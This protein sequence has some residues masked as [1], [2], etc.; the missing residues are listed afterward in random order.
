MSHAIDG[1]L[2]KSDI[3]MLIVRFFAV[4][5][6]FM[7]SLGAVS[8]EY[9]WSDSDAF[10]YST[11]LAACRHIVEKRTTYEGSQY[12]LVPGSITTTPIYYPVTYPSY[13]DATVGCRFSFRL[14]SEVNSGNDLVHTTENFSALRHGDGCATG[15]TYDFISG[16]CG[17]S[18]DKGEPQ[19]LTCVGNPISIVSGNKFQYD[20]DYRNGS[21][22]FG[23]S[24]NSLDGLWRATFSDRLSFIDGGAKV[25]LVKSDGTTTFYEVKGD[26]VVQESSDLGLLKKEGGAWTYSSSSGRA[27]SFDAKGRLTQLSTPN[28]YIYNIV[29]DEDSVRVQ[30][31]GHELALT[32]DLRGQPVRL[33]VDEL[34]IEY[35]Y[36]GDQLKA[37]KVTSRGHTDVRQFLYEAENKKLLTGIIDERGVRFATWNYDDQG[38]AISSQHSGA[39]GLTQVAYNAD[40]SSTVT[41]ELG[42]TTL[43][44]YQQIGGVKR[45]TSIDGEPSPGCQASNSSYTYNDRG[46][47]LTKTDAK[48][49]ITTYEY[50]DRGREISRTEASGTTLARTTTTEWD[51]DRFLP[52]RVI[53][54]NRVT[55]YSYDTQ[56]R[57][58]T[59]QSTSR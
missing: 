53:E 39:A 28:R 57:E 11:T 14:V 31:A 47:V 19:D 30:G 37:K 15:H 33:L 6:C 18:K 32:L 5:G 55:V 23:R 20:V 45:V 35:E 8:E 27:M 7:F 17:Q 52:F 40:G 36:N 26:V 43:Y 34:A 21:L 1:V 25:S 56:G 49:L 51:P 48:G 3:E 12:L 38:R 41:N 4:L 59:R 10:H 58:L 24:Y 22:I 2:F 42:K 54:P 13:R 46:L 9:S 44:R 16:E 29:Y 50:D